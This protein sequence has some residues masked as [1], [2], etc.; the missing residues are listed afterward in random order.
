M[1]R[2][3]KDLERDLQWLYEQFSGGD[4]VFTEHGIAGLAKAMKML[5][6]ATSEEKINK[7]YDLLDSED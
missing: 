3:K 7:L 1:R 5:A 6:E 4:E 2:T